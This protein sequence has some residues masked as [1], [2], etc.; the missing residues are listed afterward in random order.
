MNFGFVWSAI[1]QNLSR[2][3]SFR[4]ENTAHQN[5]YARRYPDPNFVGCFDQLAGELLANDSAIARGIMHCKR[6]CAA[7]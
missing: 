6:V 7:D 3:F 1:C 4:K 2:R 5:E